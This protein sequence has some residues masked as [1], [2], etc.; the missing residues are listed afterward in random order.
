MKLSA[1]ESRQLLLQLQLFRSIT[2]FYKAEGE[3]V[4]KLEGGVPL[5]IIINF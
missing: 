2:L 3:P 1:G 5:K 4:F